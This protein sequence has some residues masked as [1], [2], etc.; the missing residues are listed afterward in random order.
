M[1]A[2]PGRGLL[3]AHQDLACHKDENAL[4][5]GRVRVQGADAV[6][7][8]LERQRRQLAYNGRGPLHFLALR[9]NTPVVQSAPEKQKAGS[10]QAWWVMDRAGTKRLFAGNFRDTYRGSSSGM[11]ALGGFREQGMS[12]SC[13]PRTSKVRN[14]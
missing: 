12:M 7:A 11:V 13:M 6:L 9:S 1:H 8:L 4:R 5:G 2:R 3:A 10:A 14:A